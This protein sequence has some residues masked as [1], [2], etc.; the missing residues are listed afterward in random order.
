MWAAFGHC[1]KNQED[2]ECSK[3]RRHICLKLLDDLPKCLQH[4]KIQLCIHK[5]SDI[6]QT[7]F[8]VALKMARDLGLAEPGDNLV[9]L[10]IVALLHPKTHFT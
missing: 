7:N 3:L 5:N 10:W 9:K 4:M 2:L 8:G 1:L 6:N